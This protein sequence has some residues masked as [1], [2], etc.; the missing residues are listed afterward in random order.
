[1][2]EDGLVVSFLFCTFTARKDSSVPSV[3]EKHKNKKVMAIPYRKVKRKII[4]ADRKQHEAWVLKQVDYPPIKFEDFVKECV[5][6]QQVSESQM[7][8]I[9]SAM[10][11]RLRHYL[12]LGHSVQ[13]EGVG[14]LK[15]VFNAESAETPE[16]LDA[17]NIRMVKVRF[18]P[19]KEF[20]DSLRKMEFVDLDTLGETDEGK[21]AETV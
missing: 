3:N 18:F 13:I 15:L 16:E 8:G 19:H 17:Q 21:G 11:N 14:T 5:M 10:S 20:Q 12:E 9:A 7:K 2:S 6:S 1:M 4:G